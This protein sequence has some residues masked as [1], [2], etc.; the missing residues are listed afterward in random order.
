M[1]QQFFFLGVDES[2]DGPLN[3]LVFGHWSKNELNIER[4]VLQA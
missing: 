2:I 4:D 3:L 1:T